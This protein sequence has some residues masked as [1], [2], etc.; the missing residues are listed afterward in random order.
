MGTEVDSKPV[1]KQ[2]DENS[3]TLSQLGVETQGSCEE[4]DSF[5]ENLIEDFSDDDD[6]ADLLLM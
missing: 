1:P 5:E 4:S 2:D 3:V 6:L